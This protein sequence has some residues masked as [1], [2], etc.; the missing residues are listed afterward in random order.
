M[1]ASS[2]PTPDLSGDSS[3]AGCCTHCFVRDRQTHRRVY[4][5]LCARTIRPPSTPRLWNAARSGGGDSYKGIGRA[6]RA[7]A[8]PRFRRY[9]S[10]G[11]YLGIGEWLLEKPMCSDSCALGSDG[12]KA[13]WCNVSDTICRLEERQSDKGWCRMAGSV[14]VNVRFSPSLGDVNRAPQKK[15]RRGM[16]LHG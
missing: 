6:G 10:V 15:L 9:M 11:C 13:H 5:C 1:P 4:G 2:D 14:V 16:E 7:D 8:T 12:E 3:T